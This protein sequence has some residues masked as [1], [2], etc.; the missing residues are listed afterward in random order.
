MAALLGEIMSELLDT[1]ENYIGYHDNTLTKNKFSQ[2]A[3]EEFVKACVEAVKVTYLVEKDIALGRKMSPLVKGYI[4]EL[5]HGVTNG[6]FDLL[7]AWAQENKENL[8]YINW[9]Y[10]VLLAESRHLLDS[11]MLYVERDRPKKERFYEN[12]F[13][14]GNR[15]CAVRHVS[16]NGLVRRG[17]MRVC[18]KRFA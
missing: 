7:E 3:Y 8:D 4:E 6:N 13:C 17:R 1:W 16:G 14:C 12:R 5:I 9:Y 18:E 11:F 15:N 2:S 10:E